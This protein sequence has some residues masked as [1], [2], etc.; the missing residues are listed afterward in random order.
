MCVTDEVADGDGAEPEPKDVDWFQ[1]QPTGY[2]S[3]SQLNVDLD[4]EGSDLGLDSPDQQP[5]S[6]DQQPDSPDQQP[7]SPDQQPDSPEPDMQE[8]LD[9]SHESVDG[10]SYRSQ[11]ATH[12]SNPASPRDEAD[13]TDSVQAEEAEDDPPPKSAHSGQSDKKQLA[14]DALSNAV[15]GPLC[16]ITQPDCELSPWLRAITVGMIDLA[17]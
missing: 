10:L 2:E 8:S 4:A 1:G 13:E 5:D 16:L 15:C 3:G 7:D 12:R 9:I 6:P 17:C 11:P 14:A